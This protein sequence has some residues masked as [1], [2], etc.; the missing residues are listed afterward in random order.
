[1][2]MS[3]RELKATLSAAVRRVQ[4]GESITVTSHRRP[5]ALLVPALPAGDSDI[6]RLL[7]AGVISQRPR[8][9]GIRRGAPN[10]L[11]AGAGWVSDAVIEDRG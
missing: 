1:M 10:P 6:D 4:A 11:P 7:A 2:N 5:V 3:L 9:G 8:P